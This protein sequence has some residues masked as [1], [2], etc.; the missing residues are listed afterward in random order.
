MSYLDD[1]GE[2][3]KG[4]IAPRLLPHEDTDQLFRLYALLARVKGA[5]VSAADVHDA[6]SAWMAGLDP[7]HKSLRPFDELDAETRAADEPFV[8]AIRAVARELR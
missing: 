3:I 6:W 2:Q 5:E 8:A 7:A 1:L 4:R